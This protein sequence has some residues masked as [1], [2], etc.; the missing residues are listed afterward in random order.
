MLPSLRR[1]AGGKA[2]FVQPPAIILKVMKII[3]GKLRNLDF[4]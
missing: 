2:F 3:K 4:S 1:G